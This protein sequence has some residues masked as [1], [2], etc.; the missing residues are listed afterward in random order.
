MV[1]MKIMPILHYTYLT[2]QQSV[3]KIGIIIEEINGQT[4]TSS[5]FSCMLWSILV[6]KL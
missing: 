3:S 5:L 4:S 6:V 2:P 1:N